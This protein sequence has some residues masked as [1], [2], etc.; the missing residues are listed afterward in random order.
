MNSFNPHDQSVRAALPFPCTP[1]EV[2]DVWRGREHQAGGR[3]GPAAGDEGLSQSKA[4]FDPWADRSAGVSM[5]ASAHPPLLETVSC[6]SFG[7]QSAHGA[8]I[9]AHPRPSAQGHPAGFG[10]LC[11]KEPGTGRGASGWS[12]DSANI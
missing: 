6:R 2:T 5:N 8:W 7:G 10:V 3:V 12:P 9:E 11:Q 1:E 4:S